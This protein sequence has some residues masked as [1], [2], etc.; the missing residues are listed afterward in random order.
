LCIPFLGDIPSATA[1]LLGDIGRLIDKLY[2]VCLAVII[3]I[4]LLI[5]IWALSWIFGKGGVRG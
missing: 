2:N 1:S 3:V 4:V 5:V